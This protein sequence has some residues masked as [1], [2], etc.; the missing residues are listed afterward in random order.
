VKEVNERDMEGGSDRGVMVKAG[1]VN[2]DETGSWI[3]FNTTSKALQK[4]TAMARKNASL[5]K[6][7]AH[8]KHFIY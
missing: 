2:C 8:R 7:S 4:R 1:E 3:T 5:S 6:G